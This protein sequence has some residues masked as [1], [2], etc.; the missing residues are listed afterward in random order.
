MAIIQEQYKNTNLELFLNEL[1]KVFDKHT[2]NL[3][4]KIHKDII[5]IDTAIDYGLDLWGKLLG[6]PR[7]V[8][9]PANSGE[10]KSLYFNFIKK[11]FYKLQFFKENDNFTYMRLDDSNYRII[12]K[13][14]LLKLSQDCTYPKINEYIN[15]LFG[16]F[17][18]TSF[19]Q[20]SQNMRFTTYVFRFEIPEWLKFVIDK[21]DILPRPAGVGMNYIESTAYYIGFQGQS[22][23]YK[24]GKRDITN[25]YKSI[26]YKQT[27]D[28]ILNR[29]LKRIEITKFYSHKIYE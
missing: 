28:E 11:D 12:L 3:I 16:F 27:Y 20:D 2:V 26:F 10:V 18:G 8:P 25:F 22:N 1:N 6:F 14:L 9:V 19:V 7:Y 21:Y 24:T 5:N 29:K 23:Y 4:S 15:Y 17:G 13:C